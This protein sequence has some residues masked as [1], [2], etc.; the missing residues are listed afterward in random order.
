MGIGGPF[1]GSK[2]WPGHDAD[3]SSSFSA[4]VVVCS[5]TALLEARFLS[6]AQTQNWLPDSRLPPNADTTISNS[7]ASFAYLTANCHPPELNF[8]FLHIAQMVHSHSQAR[9]T[10]AIVEW[11]D[12]YCN[13]SLP[14]S[15][16]SKLLSPWVHQISG[17]MMVF[18]MSQR[19][20]LDLCVKIAD[21]Y[22]LCLYFTMFVI[23]EP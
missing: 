6:N 7:V 18:K 9:H 22:I 5:R 12:R 11:T 17:K 13:V 21:V 4:E 14:T 3:H 20:A 16:E 23:Q 15:P 19:I 2:A 8:N 10:L 1:S